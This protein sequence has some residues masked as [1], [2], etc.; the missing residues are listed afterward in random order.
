MCVC[1]RVSVCACVS[2]YVSGM[3]H[4]CEKLHECDV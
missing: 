1:L 3:P 4:I 2:Y